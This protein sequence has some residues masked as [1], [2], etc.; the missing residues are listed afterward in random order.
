AADRKFIEDNLET[1]V[2]RTVEGKVLGAVS[3][4]YRDG[5]VDEVKQALQKA[6]KM[7]KPG[8]AAKVDAKPSGHNPPED[9]V[10]VNVTAKV[11]DDY[12][13]YTLERL[14]RVVPEAKKC[15]PDEQRSYLK[16]YD[17]MGK[18]FHGALGRDHLWIRK[19]EVEALGRGELPESLKVRI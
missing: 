19:G 2:V 15:K 9:V 6:L 18:A 11:L 3:T 4:A 7:F 17:Q 8:E 1:F 16:Y 10:V 13:P 12:Q 5:Y 14:L